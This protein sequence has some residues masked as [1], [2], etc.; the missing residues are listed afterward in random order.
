MT[1]VNN[2]WIKEGQG[3]VGLNKWIWV[4]IAIPVA[5]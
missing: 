4:K 2:E 1:W 5:K 3:I